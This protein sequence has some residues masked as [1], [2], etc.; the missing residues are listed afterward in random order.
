M[1]PLGQIECTRN[2]IKQYKLLNRTY[3]GSTLGERGE[4]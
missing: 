4:I 3:I 2:I 1:C